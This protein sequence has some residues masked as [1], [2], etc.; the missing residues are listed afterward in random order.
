M[1]I[2]NYIH[3]NVKRVAVGTYQE[4]GCHV[5][6][7]KLKLVTKLQAEHWNC[8]ECAYCHT[9][10]NTVDNAACQHFYI[11]QVQLGILDPTPHWLM[12]KLMM[13]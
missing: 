5:L 13:T 10:V 6:H 8:I 3:S 11:L 2:R 9:A 12:L 1:V 4:S 7:D